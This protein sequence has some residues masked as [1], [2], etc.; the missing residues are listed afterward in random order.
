MALTSLS[1][2]ASTEGFVLSYKTDEILPI[3]AVTV[4]P[5]FEVG[6]AS[7]AKLIE[8]ATTPSVSV[9]VIALL[10]VQILLPVSVIV[11]AETP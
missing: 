6:K 10:A 9:P 11:V 5:E 1:V 8:K 7:S 3:T 2:P 4:V